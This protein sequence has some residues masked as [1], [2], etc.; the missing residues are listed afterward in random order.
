M[1]TYQKL[2]EILGLLKKSGLLP[3]SEKWH[4][5]LMRHCQAGTQEILAQKSVGFLRRAALRAKLLRV[6]E[7]TSPNDG[8]LLLN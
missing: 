2:C 8:C 4:F 6:G 3:S 1:R 7:L 5:A